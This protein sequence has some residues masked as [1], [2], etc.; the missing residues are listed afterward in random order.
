MH[1]CIILAMFYYFAVLKIY[2]ASK[3]FG[4]NHIHKQA[5]KKKQNSASM[6]ASPQGYL[7]ISKQ[8]SALNSASAKHNGHV[9]GLFALGPLQT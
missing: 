6:E 1:N 8:R 9:I 4:A 7:I 2:V 3:K 5:I